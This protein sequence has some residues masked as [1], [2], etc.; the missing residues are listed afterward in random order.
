MADNASDVLVDTILA[1]GVDTVF[2]IPGDGINGV[3]EALRVRKDR[4]RFIQVRHEEAAAFMACAYA[5]YTGKLGCC[6]ATSGPGGIHL[7]N[8]LYD[9]KLD[10]APVLA[11]TGQTYSDL[12]GSQFQQDVDLVRLFEDVSVYNQMVINPNQIRMLADEACRHARNHRGVA[13]INVPI[14]YQVKQANGK[15]S[16]HKVAG[17][18]SSR[19]SKPLVVPNAEDLQAAAD[20]LNVAKRP[21]LL[22]GAGALHA[23]DQVAQLAETLG[24]P[25][26]KALLGK[27][28]LPDDHPLTTGGLG[29]LGTA[30]SEDAIADCDCILFV[31]TSFPYQ[32]YLPKH[33]QAV[34]I[35]I[36]D[37]ADRIGLRYPVKVGLV[38]DAG[39]TIA[40]LLPLVERKP[41]RRFL[42]K[43]QASVK[44]W[45]E[46][47]ETRSMRD[48]IPIK[49]QRV[50]WELS[51]V[52]ADDAIISGD[53]GTNTSWVARQFRIR[54]N[55]MFSCSGTLATMAP[56]LPYA[57]AAAIAY[58]GRQS[59][60][61][62]G[63]GGFTMLMGEFATAVKYNLPVCTVIIKNNSLGQ[64]K[65]EQIV[66]LGN[67]EYVVD[68]QDIDFARFAE[69][70]GGLGFTVT[71]PHDLR[72]TFE[73]A[74]ASG[75]PSV[76]QVVVDPNEPPMPA[77]LTLKQAEGFAKALVR[78]EPGGGQI[79]L[80][81]FRDKIDELV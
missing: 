35:Q 5:K 46:L 29:L 65:W 57:I 1:W 20:L 51:A 74:L 66:F 71:D 45:W 62:V 69:A 3:I 81:L 17:D 8:G 52:A 49:P 76:I 28:V 43:I 77:K 79:A 42:E 33:D 31:G 40:A 24:A 10:Q 19:W 64:I 22:V 63:D 38:G 7:L 54:K 41:D 58:P 32:E 13:H 16:D 4:I 23:G 6:I 11:I 70:C 34:G 36:D 14:D 60:A 59:I 67:P 68:L 73:K 21:V 56:G 27:A 30:P 72:P 44:E 2:G 18:T 75:R 26:I 80:T 50:A 9:A 15:T 78:G 37:K 61:F 48:D 12:K 39:P 55:Q 47:M 25:V 53:S